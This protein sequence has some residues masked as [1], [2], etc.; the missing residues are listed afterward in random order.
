MG[1]KRQVESRLPTPVGNFKMIAYAISGEEHMP[2]L[3]LVHEEMDPNETAYVRIHS[4]CF[5]GDV[6]SSYRCDCGEQLKAAIELLGEHK[7]VLIYLRQEGRGIG[8]INKLKAYNLQDSGLNTAEANTHLGFEADERIYGDALF[9]LRD[10]GINQLHIITNNPDK[11]N[12]LEQGGITVLSRVPLLITPRPENLGYFE[13]K[14]DI[15]GH[16]LE[17]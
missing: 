2:H 17:W 8:I 12:A 15:F 4:E 3:A 14:K 1:L 11:V 10:L 6:F 7:G 16:S 9:I 13:T 5:T